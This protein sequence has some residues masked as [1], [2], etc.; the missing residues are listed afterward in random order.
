MIRK[1]GIRISATIQECDSCTNRG[2][3]FKTEK[4]GEVGFIIIILVKYR[5]VRNLRKFT[6]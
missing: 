2:R 5:K 6:L 1:V 4:T 3:N